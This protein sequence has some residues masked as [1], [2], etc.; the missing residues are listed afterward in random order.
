MALSP[1]FA[2]MLLLVTVAFAAVETPNKDLTEYAPVEYSYFYPQTASDYEVIT[3]YGKLPEL[4]TEAQKQNWSNS[5]NRLEKSLATEIFLKYIDSNG[6]VLTYGDNS[7]GY[8]VIVFYKNLTIQKPKMDE[9]YAIID[10][11]AKDIGIQDVPVEFGHGVLQLKIEDDEVP[12]FLDYDFHSSLDIATAVGLSD[13]WSK[14]CGA[15]HESETQ[16]VVSPVDSYKPEVVAIYGKLPELKT[17]E[18]R[19]DWFN[20]D[21][22]AIAKGLRDNINTYYYPAGPIISHGRHA[23]GYFVVAIYKNL[24]VDKPL[25]DE[26]YGVFDEEAKKMDIHEVPVRFILEDFAQPDILVVDEDSNEEM[27]QD[28]ISNKNISNPGKASGKSVP[29]FGLMGGLISSLSVWLFRKR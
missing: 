14:T 23:D 1:L 18:Q 12:V 26:I 9:I 28:E 6:N 25:L 11:N 13:D 15:C 5:L 24:T 17:E 16:P 10:K 22:E 7:R 19:L 21:Q 2:A 20:K 3:T 29:G 27:P 4:E 8:F